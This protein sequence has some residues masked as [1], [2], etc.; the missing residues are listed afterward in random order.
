VFLISFGLAAIA[1]IA[2]PC[3]AAEITGH[4]RDAQSGHPI[5]GAVVEL[6]PGGRRVVCDAGGHF[7]FAG[8]E[9]GDYVLQVRYQDYREESVRVEVGPKD[10]RVE[11][12][13]TPSMVEAV[14]VRAAPDESIAGSVMN[15]DDVHSS[16]EPGLGR[17]L[18]EVPGVAA[19]RRGA[20]GLDPVVRGLRE[21]QIATVVAGGRTFPACPGRMESGIG[22]IDPEAVSRIEVVKGPYAL[23]HGAGVLSAVI[24]DLERPDRFDDHSLAGRLRVGGQT[25]TEA[26]SG[27]LTV[28][29]GN[30]R[31]GYLVSLTSRN[32]NDY[33]GGGGTEVPGDYE[34]DDLRLLA[35]WDLQEHATLSVDLGYLDQGRIDY[36]GRA[37]NARLLDARSYRIG[38]EA[39]AGGDT[40]LGYR[41]SVHSNR[42]DHAMDNEGKPNA[43][44]M[45]AV[46]DTEVNTT[47]AT[48]AFDWSGPGRGFLSAGLDAYHLN[49]NGNRIIHRVSDGALLFDDAIWADA[50]IRDVGAFMQQSLFVGE[51]Q[52]WT[53]GV[54][55]DGVKARSDPPSQYFL[56]NTEGDLHQEEFNVSA[57]VHWK[58]WF[59][60]RWSLTAGLGRAVRTASALERY[61]DRFPSTRFQVSAE[62]LG[63]P[64]IDPETAHQLDVGVK[65]EGRRFDWKLDA[66]Y[67]EIEEHGLSLRQWGQGELSRGRGRRPSSAR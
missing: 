55:M 4:I 16:V 60:D 36:P 26:T 9:S 11:I 14:V 50:R 10:R 59:Q 41:L 51:H 6:Q 34:S 15:G 49:Q 3:E 30:R 5:E 57:A 38:Y 8:L 1:G 20:L 44:M 61:S 54:R 27:H 29:G 31:S 56:D 42:V 23:E 32:G 24:V 35:E 58:T 65:R 28:E 67:R 7:S 17:I 25:N 66:F 19:V 64:E 33:E 48:L 40:F 47:S 39:L 21:D 37:M 13:L 46:A 18:R 63:N 43:Q 45:R 22:H 12:R 53:W 52:E 62:F 2:G